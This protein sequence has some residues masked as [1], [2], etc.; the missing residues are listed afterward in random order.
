M[1]WANITETITDRET[2]DRNFFQT[3]E[4]QQQQTFSLSSLPLPLFRTA[5]VSYFFS[6]S[7]PITNHIF[8]YIPMFSLIISIHFFFSPFLSTRIS[9]I[10]LAIFSLFLLSTRLRH[11]NLL[12]FSFSRLY[13][14]YYFWVNCDFV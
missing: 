3:N 6:Y 11:F 8:I 4:Q 1:L 7:L 2:T 9:P 10:F 13:P 14:F 5:E 12:F